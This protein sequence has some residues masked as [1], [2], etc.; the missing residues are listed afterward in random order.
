MTSIIVPLSIV[1]E[2]VKKRPWTVEHPPLFFG[3]RHFIAV[4]P[5]L[6]YWFVCLRSFRLFLQGKMVYMTIKL[7]IVYDK[8]FINFQL[9]IFL[10][11]VY[12]HSSQFSSL[13]IRRIHLKCQCIHIQVKVW[14]FYTFCFELVDLVYRIYGFSKHGFCI[15]IINLADKCCFLLIFKFC[16]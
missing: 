8:P 14:K 12:L 11:N 15:N 3:R 16:P 5:S 4:A 1:F 2:R 6:L 9:F 7:H 13:L 10:N